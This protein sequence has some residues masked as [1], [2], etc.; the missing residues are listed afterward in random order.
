MSC[1]STP[2]VMIFPRRGAY[3]KTY[4]LCTIYEFHPIE[5]FY[6]VKELIQ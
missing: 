5:K 6:G 4:A 1:H 2:K 3:Q